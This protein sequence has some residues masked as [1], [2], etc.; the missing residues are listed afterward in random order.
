LEFTLTTVTYT[1]AHIRVQHYQKL[2]AKLTKEN[3][4]LLLY[5]LDLLAVFSS[6]SVQNLMP[7]KNL[8]SIFQPGI[9]S[10]PQHDME[11]EQYKLS[12][13]VLEFLIDYQ[14]Y[15][16]ISLPNGGQEKEATRDIRYNHGINSVGASGSRSLKEPHDLNNL[17]VKHLSLRRSSLSLEHRNKSA[18]SITMIPDGNNEQDTNEDLK[19]RQDQQNTPSTSLNRNKSV[20]T[21]KRSRTLPSKKPKYDGA[22]GRNDGTQTTSSTTGGSNG[23]EISR[24]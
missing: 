23:N 8:A 5:I 9:L 1:D 24:S 19:R 12:Q 11:P 22:Q 14:N 6:K 21:L 17:P 13:E 10:H 3:Q 15:F 18:D 20:G 4:H 7:S 16:L 2:I